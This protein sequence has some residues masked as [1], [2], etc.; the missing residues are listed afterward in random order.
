MVWLGD[1]DTADER[2][3]SQ[4]A[5]LLAPQHLT[6]FAQLLDEGLLAERERP[7]ES[8]LDPYSALA[9]HQLLHQQTLTARRLTRLGCTVVSAPAAQLERALVDAYVRLRARRRI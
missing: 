9:A 1:I 8:W 7:A 6:L 4:A 2:A 3:L 5:Q